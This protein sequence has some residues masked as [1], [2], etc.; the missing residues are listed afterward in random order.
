MLLIRFATAN[1]WRLRFIYDGVQS[2]DLG[3]ND[4]FSD[5]NEQRI[6]GVASV[7]EKY[8]KCNRDVPTRSHL[9]RGDP[10]HR[11]EKAASAGGVGASPRE[12]DLTVLEPES[13]T[14][15]ERARAHSCE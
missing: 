11:L 6:D 12:G 13:A 8:S 15:P 5:A 3:K 10:F 14:V 7:Q 1:Q 9:Q 2:N 4:E